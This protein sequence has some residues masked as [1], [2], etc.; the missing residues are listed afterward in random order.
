MEGGYDT[1]INKVNFVLWSAGLWHR[2]VRQ[3][4][5]NAADHMPDYAVSQT[6]GLQCELH[7]NLASRKVSVKSWNFLDT[8]RNVNFWRKGLHHGTSCT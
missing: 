7:V 5:T 2:V 6:R 3:V 8:L 1:D 4:T